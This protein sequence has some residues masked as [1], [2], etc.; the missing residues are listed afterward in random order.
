[1][2]SGCRRW[3]SLAAAACCCAG[4][5]PPTQKVIARIDLSKPFHLPAGASFIA[6]QGPEVDDPIYEGEKAPGLIH[7]CLRAALSAPCAPTLDDALRQGEQ[8]DWFSSIRYLEIDRLEYP[9]G[10]AR[11]PLIHLQV[12]SLH[13]GDGDQRRVVEILARRAG[14]FEVIY[15]QYIGNNHNEEARYIRS[16]PLKG[17]V[18]AALSPFGPPFSYVLKVSR[19]TPDYRYRQVLRYRSATIYGDGNPL[20]VIDSEMPNILRRLGLWQPGQ[21]L[22][23]PSSPC[24][25]PHLVKTELWCS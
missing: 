12:S 11:P 19:L 20:A 24:P 21:P 4:A 1:M 16:G 23:L 17:S 25:H 14:R 7:L 22:P 3:L 9:N 13:S 18:V 6:T 8:A 10:G 5:A 2:I 15:R